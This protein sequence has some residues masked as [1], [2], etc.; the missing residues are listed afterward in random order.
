[1]LTTVITN[2]QKQISGGKVS[3]TDLKKELNECKH[4]LGNDISMKERAK[5]ELLCETL[6]SLIELYTKNQIN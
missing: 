6:T 2:H 1:M 4:E 3:L 5:L